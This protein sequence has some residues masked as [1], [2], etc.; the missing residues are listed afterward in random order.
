[1]HSAERRCSG[2]GA[3]CCGRI[4]MQ[5][6]NGRRRRR[7][8]W[9]RRRGA[10]RARYR[11]TRRR[12]CNTR[13]R[14]SGLWRR[15]H[16]RR[17]GAAVALRAR[18]IRHSSL[19]QLRMSPRMRQCSVHHGAPHVLDVVPLRVQ[20]RQVEPVDAGSEVPALPRVDDLADG[21][22]ARFAPVHRNGVPHLPVLQQHHLVARVHTAVRA[23]GS[24]RHLFACGSGSGSGSG[25][26]PRAGCSCLIRHAVGCIVVHRHDINRGRRS[27]RRHRSSSSSGSGGASSRDGK[28][29]ASRGSS[30]SGGNPSAAS[31]SRSSHP[32]ATHRSANPGRAPQR[33]T[34][35]TPAGRKQSAPAQ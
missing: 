12:T 11:T 24:S 3:L 6:S 10:R 22:L 32:E 13:L 16:P 5:G 30:R 27:S 26:F 18:R 19:E 4:V 7:A 28:S 14:A 21:L 35:P 1:M 25:G 9:G 17:R 2:L 23:L 34:D 31:G 29:P 15:V 20:H 8:G 33:C